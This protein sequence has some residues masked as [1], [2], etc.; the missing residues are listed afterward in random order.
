MKPSWRR[1]ARASVLVV[2]LAPLP[3]QMHFQTEQH[4]VGG[5]L[6][7][8]NTI[9]HLETSPPLP[10]GGELLTVTVCD[11][12]PGEDVLLLYGD[13]T[14]RL[15]GSYLPVFTH[16]AYLPGPEYFGPWCGWYTNGGVCGC[17]R[18]SAGTTTFTLRLPVVPSA[19]CLGDYLW[20]QALM[21]DPTPGWNLDFVTSRPIRLRVVT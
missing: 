13:S 7:Q 10:A 12:V 20:C 6:S 9:M 15:G 17:Q 21:T 18:A 3:A 8:A 1:Q 11:T 16:G 19:A 2:L 14:P 5:C 4:P